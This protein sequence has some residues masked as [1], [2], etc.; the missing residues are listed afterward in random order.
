MT[1]IYALLDENQIRYIG[2]TTCT[3]L[4]KKLNQH[5]L[6][7]FSDPDKFQWIN[8]LWKKGSTPRIKSILTY[9]DTESEYYDRMFIDHYKFFSSLRINN[10]QNI[11]IKRQFQGQNTLFV[12]N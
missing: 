1:T 11:S 2:K 6:E 8:D 12:L 3:D 7:A 10:I 9:N 5:M 4:N